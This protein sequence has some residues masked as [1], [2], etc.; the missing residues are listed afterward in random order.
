[1][2]ALHRHAHQHKPI[3][4]EKKL[5]KEMD[6]RKE[7]LI[8]ALLSKMDRYSEL[9]QVRILTTEFWY[10]YVCARFDMH[11]SSSAG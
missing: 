9:L 10:I 2:H 5:G 6:K 1:M 11:A 3:T 8:D 7:A 4:A